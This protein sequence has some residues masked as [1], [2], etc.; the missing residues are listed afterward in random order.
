VT[1]NPQGA[2]AFLHAVLPRACADGEMP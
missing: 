2:N 1:D